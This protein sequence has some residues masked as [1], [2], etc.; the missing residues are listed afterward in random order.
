MNDDT[1]LMQP[2]FLLFPP[3]AREIGR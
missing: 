1:I 3:P 2:A